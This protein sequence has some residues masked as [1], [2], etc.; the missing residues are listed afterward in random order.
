ME[1][2]EQLMLGM[3]DLEDGGRAVNSVNAKTFN[4]F[5]TANLAD[6]RFDVELRPALC[7]WW[8]GRRCPATCF[9]A[10]RRANQP[11]D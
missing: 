7:T 11:Q 4:T 3:L 1:V 10:G 2:V 6:G 8:S 9:V 5:R